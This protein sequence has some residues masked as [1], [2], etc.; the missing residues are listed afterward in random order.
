MK[1][2]NTITQG[3]ISFNGDSNQN[4]IK[5]N[6]QSNINK[7][8]T[9]IKTSKP[10]KYK[11][12]VQVPWA[13][14]YNPSA[15]LYKRTPYINDRP[16]LEIYYNALKI[17]G[18]NKTKPI[19]MYG[20]IA[21]KYKNRNDNINYILTN[22]VSVFGKHLA[23][24]TV[25][26][27]MNLDDYLHELIMFDGEIYAYPSEDKSCLKY[28]IRIIEYTIDIIES[29]EH[30]YINSPWNFLYQENRDNINTESECINYNSLSK[31]AHIKSINEIKQVLDTISQTMFG[32]PGLIYPTIVS[33]FLMRDDVDS[34]DI[35]FL[36][37]NHRHINILSTLVVDYII[38]LSPKTYEELYKIVAYVVF[39]YLGYEVENPSVGRVMLYEFTKYMGISKVQVD[40]YIENV[41]RNVGGIPKLKDIIPNNYKTK[42][43][44]IHEIGV[45]Q[46]AKRLYYNC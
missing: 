13:N 31:E 24:H 29:K 22:T 36:N 43:G 34:D 18:E 20:Y 6:K 30:D 15:I 10:D 5:Q 9:I 8:K 41:K 39:N 23:A 35:I 11:E 16:I 33:S 40:Y 4:T 14:V 19:L 27:G 44:I 7:S 28:G 1:N 32:I 2:K 25:I 38:K 42:P 3:N 45:I 21:S 37:D 26:H 12:E 17:P 46:F